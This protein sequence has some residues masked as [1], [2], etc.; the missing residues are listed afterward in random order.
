M[1]FPSH[2][3]WF[4]GLTAVILM[5]LAVSVSAAGSLAFIPM[6]TADAVGV[7]DLETNR[8]TSTVSGTVNTHGSALTPG[9]RYLVV[10]SLTAHDNQDA[11]KRPE[12]VTAEDHAAHHGGG[13]TAAS[14]S[15]GTGRLYVVDTGTNTIVRVLEVPGPVHHVLV[16]QDGRYAVSTHPMGGGISV[17][18]LESGKIVEVI[19]TGPSPNYLATTA[20]GQTLFV[21]NTGNGTISEVDTKNWFVKRN[22]R[23][24]GGPEHMALAS[25]GDHL[26]I[27]D[28]ASGEAV[29]LKLSDGAVIAR[30]E[31]GEAPHGLGLT[32][33]G[34]ALLATSQGDE[35]I[36]R[37]EL[38]SNSRKSVQL[39]PAPYHLTVSPIDGRILV[40]SRAE[41]KLW[42]LDPASLTIVD[43]VSLDGIGHQISIEAQ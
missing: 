28:A 32:T 24:G 27:N 6:G 5:S 11:P 29:A 23:I 13:S 3:A 30:Y 16:T 4:S 39:K 43:E 17:V 35:E 18:N 19:A 25:D 20:D 38:D 14:A 26:Y 31:I 8:L 9:G 7:M 36:V 15:S 34:G 42:V 40:T 2:K 10:G 21:S 41:A 37:V 33:D 22:V 12:G 1:K